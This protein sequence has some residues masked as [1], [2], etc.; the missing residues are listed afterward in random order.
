[1]SAVTSS[2]AALP[3]PELSSKRAV[4]RVPPGFCK[5]TNGSNTED[6]A[7]ISNWS[8]TASVIE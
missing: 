3:P 6:D 2:R 8:P 1:M 5:N 4:A 7:V